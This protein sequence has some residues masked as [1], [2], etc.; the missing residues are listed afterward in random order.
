MHLI[1][2][3]GI[4]LLILFLGTFISD[5]FN[6]P[7]P[8]NVIGMVLLSIAL[9]KGIVKLEDVEEAANLFLNHLAI[10]FVCPT[11]G[12]MLYFDMIKLQF[13]AIVVPTIGSI[14]IGLVVTGKV[15]QFIAN[16]K[17]VDEY[18]KSGYTK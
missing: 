8:G 16:R 2:Q 15:V 9:I 17:V 18:G 13:L 4:V 7:I 6:I 10:F 3:F 1:K 14:V 5:F 12:I 11:V